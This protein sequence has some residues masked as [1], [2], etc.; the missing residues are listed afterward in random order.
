MVFDTVIGPEWLWVIPARQFLRDDWPLVAN[1]LV[2]LVEG[3]FLSGGPLGADDCC[4]EVVVESSNRRSVPFTALFASTSGNGELLFHDAGDVGPLAFAASLAQEPQHPVFLLGPH[5]PFR[6]YNFMAD[7]IAN[8]CPLPQSV[9]CVGE[10]NWRT[11]G[12]VVLASTRTIIKRSRVVEHYLL[13]NPTEDLVKRLFLVPRFLL[14][15]LFR[16]RVVGSGW[17]LVGLG[18]TARTFDSGLKIIELSD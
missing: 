15:H 9:V 16:S 13:T 14:D 5:F 18:G 1:L 10:S 11:G 6:H 7:S 17:T 8:N 4:V 2:E 12:V 3:P